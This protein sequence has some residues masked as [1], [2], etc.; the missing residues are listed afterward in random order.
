VALGHHVLSE[1]IKVDPT[2]IEVIIKLPPPKTQKD[3]RRFLGH[4]GYYRR[5][6]ENFTKIDAPMLGLLIKDVDFIWTKQCQ[7]AFE[8]LKDKLFVASV[9][10]GPNWALPFHISTNASDT[11]IGGVLVHIEDQ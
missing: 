4:L 2:N 3:V 5:F 6:I 7:I 8:T 1:G 11:T 9:L 10:K